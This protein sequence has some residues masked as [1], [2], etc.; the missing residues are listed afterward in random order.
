MD[1]KK[2]ENLAYNADWGSGSGIQKLQEPLWVIIFATA[3]V[4]GECIKFVA[5]YHSGKVPQKI[6]VSVYCISCWPT[7][8]LLSQN[9]Q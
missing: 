2:L 5:L 4:S 9:L 1:E 8:I 3:T 6:W 7:E